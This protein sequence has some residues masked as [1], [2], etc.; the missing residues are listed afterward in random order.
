MR[1]CTLDQ[2]GWTDAL[3]SPTVASRNSSL[4]DLDALVAG[5][6]PFTGLETDAGRP[7]IDPS[8]FDGSMVTQ[9]DRA[10][11]SLRRPSRP[12]T[13]QPPPAFP[14]GV[15]LGAS[16]Q[17]GQRAGSVTRQHESAQQRAA[18]HPLGAQI[19]LRDATRR[20]GRLPRELLGEPLF[21][22]GVWGASGARFCGVAEEGVDFTCAQLGAAADR[23]PERL[24]F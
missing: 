20:A 13:P 5:S 12:R 8:V 23:S 15:R 7:R 6:G 11:P 14:P 9:V 18:L 3:S 19:H 16:P 10:P 2:S 17:S 22:S 4:A 1:L 24:D 21:E